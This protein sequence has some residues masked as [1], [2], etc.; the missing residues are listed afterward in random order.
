MIR[1]PGSRAW[2]T[3]HC[4]IAPNVVDAT[5]GMRQQNQSRNRGHLVAIT[6]LPL[7]IGMRSASRLGYACCMNAIKDTQITRHIQKCLRHDAIYR[8]AR[9]TV[10]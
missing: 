1:D 9:K 6:C 2:Q 5:L 4:N 10:W 8:A 3:Y 7:D